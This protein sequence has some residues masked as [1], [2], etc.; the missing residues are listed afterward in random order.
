MYALRLLIYQGLHGRYLWD[1]TGAV[2]VSRLTYASQ[3][4]LGLINES[5]KNQLGAIIAKAVRQSFLA[6]GFVIPLM[7]AFFVLFQIILTTS[8]INS[9]LQKNY[10]IRKNYSFCANGLIIVKPLSLKVLS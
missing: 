7:Q 4:W 2:L 5:E 8:Y 9:F 1:V 10:S 3:A 6:P